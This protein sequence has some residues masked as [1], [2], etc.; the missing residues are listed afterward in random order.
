M[1]KHQSLSTILVFLSIF[2][3]SCNPSSKVVWKIESDNDQS[4]TPS[5]RDSFT[6]PTIV[7][8]V[9]TQ[10]RDLSSDSSPSNSNPTLSLEENQ[11]MNAPGSITIEPRPFPVKQLNLPTSSYYERYITRWNNGKIDGATLDMRINNAYNGD[12]R[13]WIIGVQAVRPGDSVKINPS[14]YGP[15]T[16]NIAFNWFKGSVKVLWL[17]Y[18]INY[19]APLVVPVRET[20]VN[21]FPADPAVRYNN[22]RKSS[23]IDIYYNAMLENRSNKNG[24]GSLYKA[25]AWNRKFPWMQRGSHVDL[26]IYIYT[27]KQLY[28]WYRNEVGLSPERGIPRA[29]SKVSLDEVIELQRFPVILE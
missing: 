12:A 10:N 9:A 28:N 8:S 1:L 7:E 20:M 6:P 22:G 27:T 29:L 24:A 21:L 25:S 4:Y 26:V 17:S 11:T 16:S 3:T 2:V 19:P 18:A 23:Q 14:E 15:H 13:I 5:D